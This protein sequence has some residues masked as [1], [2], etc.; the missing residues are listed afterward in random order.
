MRKKLQNILK[1]LTKCLLDIKLQQTEAIL[2]TTDQPYYLIRNLQEHPVL[3][4]FMTKGGEWMGKTRMLMQ[5]YDRQVSTI[6]TEY[7]TVEEDSSSS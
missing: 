3:I 7:F 1:Q 6:R 4:F 2:G 5:D